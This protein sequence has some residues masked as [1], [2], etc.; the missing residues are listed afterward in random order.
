VTKR[1]IAIAGHRTSISLEEP[2][3]RA[4]SEIAVLEG[5]SMSG[6][7]A[8]ID[9]GRGGGANLSSAIRMFV[10]D[11]YRRAAAT[12][13]AGSAEVQAPVPGQAPATA[14]LRRPAPQE[15][16]IPARVLPQPRPG[17]RSGARSGA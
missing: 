5:T 14:Q 12:A 15:R 17:P 1:S 13:R 6:L 10:L 7:V 11:W 9:T 8:R 3:W 2:F 4:L 16:E